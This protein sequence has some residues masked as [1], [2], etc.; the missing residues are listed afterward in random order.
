MKTIIMITVTLLLAGCGEEYV[1]STDG[2]L[3]RVIEKCDTVSN[4]NY[5]KTTATD[6][7]I[8]ATLGGAIGNKFSDGNDG[9]TALGAVLGAVIA[10][11]PRDFYVNCREELRRVKQL[12]KCLWPAPTKTEL[13]DRKRLLERRSLR[14]MRLTY[15][16]INEDMVL[17]FSVLTCIVKL[18]KVHN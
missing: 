5:G 11:E 16:T 7:L 4:P 8:G 10:S 12:K 17:D 1:R 15:R 9:S 18:L 2:E 13:E 14:V 6:L 3:Y